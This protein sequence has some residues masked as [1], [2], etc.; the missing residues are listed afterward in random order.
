[1][2]TGQDVDE[3]AR[4]GLDHRLLELCVQLLDLGA[5]DVPPRPD[6]R[7]V[8][9]ARAG[10]EQVVVRPG[11]VQQGLGL[12]LLLG[13]AAPDHHV[14]LGPRGVGP[15]PGPE[16]A[17]AVL[18]VL[19]RRDHLL[20]EQ[21]GSPAVLLLGELEVGVGGR[22]VAP[23]L[24]LLLVA[25]PFLEPLPALLGGLG[26]GERGGLLLHPRP[27]DR[28][29]QLG[30]EIGE[31]GDLLRL[32]R[33]QLRRLDDHQ[34]LARLDPFALGDQD[35]LDPPSLLRGQSDLLDLDDAGE[36]QHLP[37]GAGRRP[38]PSQ[39]Q[40]RRGQ[41][42]QHPDRNSPSHGVEYPS[43]RITFRLAYPLGSRQ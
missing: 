25:E 37:P 34:T 12:G 10:L 32:L 23:G 43:L 13:P 17:G 2:R 1:M 30:L 14:A 35:L 4:G 28:F 31:L 15:A 26:R 41:Q 11:L 20:A 36:R 3:G 22:G 21:V 42:N 33:L 9:G 27:L 19:G 8:L 5:G 38:Q 29:L 18:V 7:D 24:F 40:A 16:V 39:A 6:H